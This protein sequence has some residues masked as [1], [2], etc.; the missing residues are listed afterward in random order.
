MP[1]GIRSLE[2]MIRIS[3]AYAKLRLSSTVDLVDT[4]NSLKLFMKAFY[5]GYSEVNPEFF[6]EEQDLLQIG[7]EV[8]YKRQKFVRVENTFENNQNQDSHTNK[9]IKKEKNKNK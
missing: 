4:V 5:G 1:I 8:R 6:K 3:T 7:R 2:S 9:K